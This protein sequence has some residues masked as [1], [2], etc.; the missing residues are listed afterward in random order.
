MDK[1]RA[2][3]SIIEDFRHQGY[4]EHKLVDILIIIMCTVLCGIGELCEIVKYAENKREFLKNTFGIDKIPSKPTFCRVLNMIDGGKIASIIIE[5]MQE[6]IENVGNIIAVDGKAIRSTAKKG[7][8][9]S[10]LQILTAYLTESGIVLGQES[11]HNKTN[12]IPV[13]QNMLNYLEISGKT[14]TADAMHCQRETCKKIIEKR[15]DYVFGL[16]ENQKNF[17]EEVELFINDEN[18]INEMEI[19]TTTNKSHGRIEKRICYKILNTDWIS[20]KKDWP[21]LN[22][23]FAV[24]R[25]ITTKY[26]TSENINYYISSLTDSAENL[27]FI[28][29]EHWKIE[30]MHWMLDVIFSED[31]TKMISENGLK[32]LNIF[33]KLSLLMHKKYIALQR[34][35]P[36]IKGNMFDCLLNDDKLV[37][38]ILNL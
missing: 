17:Y 4:V 16:K 7:S 31:E 28:T 11:I 21:G 38:V 18:S 25:I 12:E 27:L 15:G 3:F 22:D 37:Q 23:V 1:I 30:S 2:K 32:T 35:K 34:K 13:F 6:N 33:R 8:P 19:F 9:H 5:I 10:A 14:I 24:K 29:R 36:S 26:E 20:M